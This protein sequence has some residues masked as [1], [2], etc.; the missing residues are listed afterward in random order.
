MF[1]SVGDA[2]TT[3]TSFV[4]IVDRSAILIDFA[5]PSSLVDTVKVGDPVETV[6]VARPALKV[7]GKVTAISNAI[8]AESG[9]FSVRAEVPNPK[10]SLRGGMAF[11]VTM[12]FAGDTYV[13]VDPL[14]I[15]WGSDGAYVWRVE[16]KKVH[17]VAVRIIQR[18][19][20]AV[21]VAGDVKKGDEIVTEG[22]SGLRPGAEVSVI[23]ANGQ[24]VAS[25]KAPSPG[26]PGKD[27]GTPAKP[28]APAS[29]AAGS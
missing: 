26:Q 24:P 19:T 15:Q 21:L 18:N 10:D 11:T 20:G 9:T 25:E 8:D 12:N 29:P 14:S 5:M 17:K 6:P 27:G 23:A 28:G 22:L 3:Q 4:T 16:A 13:A 1:Y 7:T 2:V